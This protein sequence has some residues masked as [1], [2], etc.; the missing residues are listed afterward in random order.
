M[1]SWSYGRLESEAYKNL[2]LKTGYNI[3]VEILTEIDKSENR[4]IVF[5]R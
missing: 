2:F 4:D 3:P 5:K 1:I